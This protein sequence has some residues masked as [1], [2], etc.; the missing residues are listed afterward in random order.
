MPTT[1]PRTDLSSAPRGALEVRLLGL[2]DFDAALGLQEWLAYELSGRRDGQGVLLLCEHPPLISVGRQG[3]RTQIVAGDAEL[4]A[5]DMPVRWISRSGGAVVHAPG[6]LAAY[7]LLPLD[8]L[9]LGLAEFRRRFETA[10]LNVCHELRVPTKR[11]DDGP[12]L[13][14][15]GG[16]VAHFGAVVKSWVT[17]QGMWLNVCPQPGFLRMVRS[18]FDVGPGRG[19]CDATGVAPSEPAL[20][21][22][23]A[24]VGTVE[25]RVTSLQDQLQ[26]RVSMHL[27]RE[28]TLRHIAAA[29]GFKEVHPFTGHPQL[30]R[31]R[32]RVCTTVGE[33]T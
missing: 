1:L 7:L 2:L 3:S 22:P 23:R 29:F 31:S 19:E 9:Q 33:R 13:W 32:Q 21:H 10:L 24:A 17:Q 8:R 30:I 18:E 28:A 4:A 20:V 14:T 11:L 26:R 16:Q 5:C 25:H 27:A 12:G 15:R 6:Q